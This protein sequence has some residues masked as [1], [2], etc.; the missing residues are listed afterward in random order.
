VAKPL[1]AVNHNPRQIAQAWPTLS[2]NNKI[3]IT[4]IAR[5]DPML[6]QHGPDH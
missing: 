4:R 1:Y 3:G 2:L 5:N 6:G